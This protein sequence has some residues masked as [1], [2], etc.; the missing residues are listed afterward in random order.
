MFARGLTA[1]D[2]VLLGAGASHLQVLRRFALRPQP[3]VRL[4]LVAPE[5]HT[6]YP[7]LLPGLIRGD[8]PVTAAC[9]DLAMLSMA[10]GARLAVADPIRLDLARRMLLLRNDATLS[11]DLL[12]IDV[13]GESAVPGV[14]DACIPTSPPGRFLAQLPA[15]EVALPNGARVAIIAGGDPGTTIDTARHDGARPKGSDAAGTELALALARRF[16]G[17]L[18]VVL[19]GEAAEPLADAPL[20]AR[21]AI[22]ATLVDAGV[23]L[24]CGVR[25]GALSEGRLALSDGSFLAADVALWASD[26]LPPGFLAESG[27]ACDAAGR[28]L[29]TKGQRSVS[30]PTVFAAGDCAA[31][32]HR[33]WTG[34]LLSANLRRAARGRG[35]IQC[36]DRSLPPRIGVAML[37]LGGGRAVA[38]SNGVALAGAAVGRWKRWTDRRGLQSY[39][40]KVMLSPD[41]LA[42]AALQRSAPLHTGTPQ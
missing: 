24:A 19:V 41:E 33:P 8:C 40:P 36:P 15:L 27:L 2:L 42:T 32:P 10:A 28:V 1:T 4:T 35:L 17:R 39:T 31:Q 14:R 5:Q 34:L 11:Y 18:R 16:G 37:D 13:S 3:G 7:G 29:V 21:R 23:E 20:R 26:T 25:A 12:S 6:P 9:I 38:W 22:R 30:H